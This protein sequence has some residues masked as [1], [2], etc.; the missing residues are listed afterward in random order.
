MSANSNVTVGRIAY[1]AL[2]DAQRGTLLTAAIASGDLDAL[3]AMGALVQSSEPVSDEHAVILK[4]VRV[5]VLGLSTDKSD[6]T[7][8]RPIR[9]GGTP[10]NLDAWIAGLSGGACA[11]DP[12]TVM[13]VRDED[14]NE[15]TVV[16]GED[17]DGNDI[18]TPLVDIRGDRNE[19]GDTRV[20]LADGTVVTP[21]DGRRVTLADLG[22]DVE[23]F[24]T[25]REFSRDGGTTWGAVKWTLTLPRPRKVK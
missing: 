9:R 20:R 14:G 3:A 2:T 17:E 7:V 21:A 6:L 25:V 15:V 18:L 10:G 16:T 23:R 8:Y 1:S 12:A 5:Y 24:M 22:G 13:Y 4:M 11:I 19:T